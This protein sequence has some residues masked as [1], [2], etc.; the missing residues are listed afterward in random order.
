VL[1]A[2]GERVDRAVD[3]RR[4][5]ADRAVVRPYAKMFLRA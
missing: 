4:E 3:G 5:R 2:G 1:G